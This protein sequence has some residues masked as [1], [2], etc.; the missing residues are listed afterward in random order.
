MDY[1]LQQTIATLVEHGQWWAAPILAGAAAI[2][3]IFPPFPGDTVTLAGAVLAR[4]GDWSITLVFSALMVGNLVGAMA[5]YYVGR[6]LLNPERLA[7]RR[8]I[9]NHAGAMQRLLA[10]FSRYGPALLLI[11]RFLP[12]IRA[13]FFV[14]A[15]MARLHPL[16]VL[17]YAALSAALW[18]VL[19]LAAGFL[20]GDN[21][22]L[23]E[24]LFSRYF[25]VAWGVVALA[26]VVIVWRRL[27]R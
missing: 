15:G 22:P 9:A 14:A 8:G 11:N 17:L 27:R 5:D 2:E 26:A 19:L 10:G 20:V 3:Y 24:E 16:W 1:S 13:L 4:L 12:G 25:Q 7:K 6:R 18:T 21:L 23:L